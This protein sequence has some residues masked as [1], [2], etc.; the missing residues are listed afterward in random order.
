MNRSF[1][2][3]VTALALV[4]VAAPAALVSGFTNDGQDA[5]A[6]AAVAGK[7]EGNTDS[8]EGVLAFTCELRIEEG[9]LKG[10][11]VAGPYSI[12][13][14]SGSLEGD[15]LQLNGAVD[16]M[17]MTIGGTWKAGVFEGMWYV[18]DASGA[19]KMTKVPAGKK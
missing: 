3:I 10:N 17:A 11:M 2:L 14:T 4:A 5:K 7:Y 15:K 13:I 16:G 6:L 12:A 9:V 18:E 19:M 1:R 8:P